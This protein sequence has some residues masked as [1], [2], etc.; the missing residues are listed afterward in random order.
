MAAKQSLAAILRWTR[1]DG[2]V[3]HNVRILYAVGAFVAVAVHP[4]ARDGT[5]P[6]KF[7]WALEGAQ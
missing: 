1:G 2:I 6:E 7:G 4:Q 5:A 3:E